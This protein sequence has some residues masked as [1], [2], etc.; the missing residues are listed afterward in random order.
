[1]GNHRQQ[2][3]PASLRIATVGLRVFAVVVAVAACAWLAL[4]LAFSL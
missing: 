3:D 1:M 4:W 2:D